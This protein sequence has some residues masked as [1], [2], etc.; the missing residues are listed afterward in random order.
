LLGGERAKLRPREGFVVRKQYHA[1]PSEKGLR[2]WDVDGLVELSNALPSRRVPLSAIW[3]L[4]EVR[5]FDENRQ[6]PTCRA[7][8]EHM[9]LVLDAD[10][11]FPVLLGSDGRVMDGMH[12][13]L[14]VALSGGTEIEARKFDVEP[15]PDY[16]GVR[17]DD[18][19]Y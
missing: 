13:V 18:L 11:S 2:V 8:L 17:L 1:V 10:A 19:P 12:R 3:E 7:V 9:R 5:W 15:A 14:K 16:E 4:D 6:P